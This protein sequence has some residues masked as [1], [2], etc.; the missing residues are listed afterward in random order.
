MNRFQRSVVIFIIGIVILSILVK[1]TQWV[2]L[3]TKLEPG[4]EINIEYEIMAA[5]AALVL[6]GFGALL[7]NLR[8][9]H[10]SRNPDE[11]DEFVVDDLLVTDPSRE[12]KMKINPLLWVS[13]SLFTGLS[14][15]LSV[16]FLLAPQSDP[17]IRI[18]DRDFGAY[19]IVSCILL[20][21][22]LLINDL[23]TSRHFAKV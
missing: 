15:G 6:T 19:S 16:W 11:H 7:F 14:I 22:V 3:S 2:L 12:R 1:L 4:Q 13:C 23:W 18:F 17:V 5:M 10:L 20:F 8:M 21:G 9:L